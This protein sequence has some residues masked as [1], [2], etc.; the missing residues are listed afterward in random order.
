MALKNTSKFRLYEKTIVEFAAKKEGYFLVLSHDQNFVRMLR[1]LLNKDLVIGMDRIR[2]V[3][4]EDK[5]LREFK[6][7]D[8]VTQGNHNVLLF[9]ERV[10]HNRST[11]PFIK[12][13][14]SLHGDIHIVVLT[15][16]VER[17]VL[18]LLHEIG[19]SNFITKPVSVNTM[20]EK[21][22]FT[23]KPQGKIG[24]YIDKGKEYLNKGLWD[25]AIAMSEK[26]L[27]LKPGSSAGLMIRGDALKGKGEASSAE[28]AYM[29]AHKGASL[30]L[31][32][33]K[34]L[35]GLYREEGNLKKQ[36]AFLKKLDRLSPLNVERKISMG[37]IHM[38]FGETD[39]AEKYF[40]EAVVNAR[41]EAQLMIDEV[42]RSIAE[43]CIDSSPAMAE[44]FF[45]NIIDSKGGVLRESDI[46]VFNRLGIALRRQGR[47]D[48]AVT[49]YDQALGVCPE[50]ENLHFN[51]AVALTEAARHG[52][53][54]NAM[55]RVLELKPDFGMQSP[56]LCFNMAVMFSNARRADEAE[57]YLRRTLELDPGHQGAKKML[58]D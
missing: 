20:I 9:V 53:A 43:K 16:E 45:R 21:M 13:L 17:Q 47:F 58:K 34:K 54:M 36:L 30:Y 38:E 26:V 18:I 23:I 28:E 12:N 49:E 7:L 8:K 35:A 3:Q 56:V 39:E 46:E 51:R 42:S 15:A 55:R 25:E 4:E 50:D 2:V 1:Q 22:A 40:D 5:L 10:L 32:P 29:K 48:D 31:E 44:K 37:E 19:V 14:K 41:K 27:E 6:E 24:Q 52:E 33:L 57:T 11:L